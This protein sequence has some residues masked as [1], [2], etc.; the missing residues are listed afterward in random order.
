MRVRVFVSAFAIFTAVCPLPA[1]SDSALLIVNPDEGN[2]PVPAQ[3]QALEAELITSISEFR[4]LLVSPEG[5][6]PGDQPVKF[7]GELLAANSN[8][9]S[10]LLTPQALAS[11]RLQLDALQQIGVKAITLKAGFPMLYRPFHKSA[12]EYRKYLTFYKAV[13]KDIRS[14]KLTVIVDSAPTFSDPTYSTLNVKRFYKSFRSLAAYR[15]ARTAHSKNVSSELLPDFLNVAA[16]PDTEASQTGQMVNDP[17]AYAALVNSISR[18]V[19]SQRKTRRVLVGAGI[20]TWSADYSAFI[21][22]LTALRSLDLID[23]HV[24]PVVRTYLTRLIEIQK[25]VSA[26]GKRMG[27]SEAWLYKVG[28]AELSQ[29]FTSSQVYARD[30]YSY[31]SQTDQL[32]LTTMAEFARRANLQFYSGFWSQI[33]SS[34]APAS[35]AEGLSY[36]QISKILNAAATASMKAGTVSSLGAR[37]AHIIAESE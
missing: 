30:A 13:I 17:K 25:L 33:Y 7:T 20:G 11:A 19:H 12:V 35:T 23:I 1:A 31:W 34:Y 9:G 28:S 5:L 15:A 2:L 3:F 14:R 26:S 37:Y 29:G 27:I 6:P 8:R 10:Q 24:Y 18:G 16:E 32:F 36:S 21:T 4:D 22:N